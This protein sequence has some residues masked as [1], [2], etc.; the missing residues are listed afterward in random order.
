MAMAHGA[1]LANMG[2]AWW[3]PIVQI[4]GDTFGGRPVAAVF[5]SNG[6]ARA[7]SSLTALAADSSTRQANTIR[8][9][10]HSITLTRAVAM[11]TIRRGSYSTQCI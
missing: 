4:P 2:E 3:V 1:D 11:S 8:W 5:A 7:A 10:E 9:P 6:P